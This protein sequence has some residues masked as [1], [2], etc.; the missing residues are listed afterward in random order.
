MSAPHGHRPVGMA[1][2]DHG[3]QEGSVCKSSFAHLCYVLHHEKPTDMSGSRGA[4]LRLP[5]AQEVF[6]DLS[7]HQPSTEAHRNDGRS[8]GSSFL[9]IVVVCPSQVLVQTVCYPGSCSVL[10]RMKHPS[11]LSP[12]PTAEELSCICS[13]CSCHMRT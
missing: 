11:G 8:D 7:P 13:R 2:Y 12:V 4:V 10:V 1:T 6:F 5:C 3:R 9:H